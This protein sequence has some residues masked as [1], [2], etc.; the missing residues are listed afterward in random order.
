MVL[1]FELKL[2]A[3]GTS[4]GEKFNLGPCD[5]LKLMVDIQKEKLAKDANNETYVYLT[6]KVEAEI[7]YLSDIRINGTDSISLLIN[8]SD[9]DASNSVYSDPLNKSR[10]SIA[11]VGNE[12]NDYS[13]HIVV[14]LIPSENSYVTLVEVSPGLP[15]RR[16][17][18]F[19]NQLF[20][21]CVKCN[22][23]NYLVAHPSGHV[24]KSGA[25]VMMVA[26]H[27]AELVAFPSQEFVNDLNQGFLDS[28]EII[29]TRQRGLLWDNGGGTKE[30][31][32]SIMLKP[33][34]EMAA[35]NYQKMSDALVIASTQQFGTA[36]IK[37]RTQQGIPK[38]VDLLTASI[39]LAED[40][41]YVKKEIIDGFSAN[42]DS[43]FSQIHSE[44]NQKMLAYLIRDKDG[45]LSIV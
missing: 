17:E 6:R 36:K 38:T 12:G 29:D 33:V 32:R 37:F 24:D 23:S 15:S 44:I 11:K 2:S 35:T 28:I 16:I 25:P 34:A 30:I 5:L 9:R 10:R 40:S 20:R 14:N 8:L 18:N 21:S 26:N 31:T 39:S 42:L 7:M 43:S 19:L 3:T 27:R 13:A 1:F 22:R 45:H 41:I 4:A